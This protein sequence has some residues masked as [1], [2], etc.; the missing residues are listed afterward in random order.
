MNKFSIITIFAT[1]AL[2]ACSSD[3]KTEVPNAPVEIRLTTGLDVQTRAAYTTT[4]TT[5]FANNQDV[6]VWIDDHGSGT[7]PTPSAFIDAWQL[8]TSGVNLTSTDKFYFPNTGNNIDIYALHGILTPSIT[9]CTQATPLS[10]T[11][12]PAIGMVHTVATDQSA[13]NGYENSDLLCAHTKDASKALASH[14]LTFN[15]LLSKVEVYLFSGNGV[16]KADIQGTDISII[17]SKLQ[18][19]VTLSKTPA[20]GKPIGS[21]AASAGSTTGSILMRKQT[22]DDQIISDYTKPVSVVTEDKHAY[23]FAEAV[24]VPQYISSDGAAT[25]T[26][27]DFIQI[28]F[29]GGTGIMKAKVKN[30][31][32]S[33][34]LYKFYVTLSAS[35][36]SIT[37]SISDWTSG[38]TATPISAE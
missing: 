28:A 26:S 29:A 38:G 19:D 10:G 23:A 17:N 2:M 3:D 32:E 24:I 5:A 9:A 4:Q 21:V 34:K 6:Y 22:Q 37:T 20:A 16:S 11:D 15:H 35:E 36:I 12:F 13:A 31:F 27:V 33:G 18:A 14:Q 30:D 8:T 7:T 1:L 25:G